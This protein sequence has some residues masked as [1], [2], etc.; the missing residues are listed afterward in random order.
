MAASLSRKLSDGFDAR[1]DCLRLFTEAAKLARIRYPRNYSSITSAMDV[2]GG[3]KNNFEALR[4]NGR[5][6]PLNA[7]FMRL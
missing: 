4:R 3:I 7:Y 1:T 2:D 5:L 6:Q